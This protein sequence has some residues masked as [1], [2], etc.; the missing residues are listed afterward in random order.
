MRMM[1]RIMA[2]MPG[3][4]SCKELDEK[5]DEY[6]EGELSGWNRFRFAMHFVMCKACAAYAAG[7][8]KT[9]GAV[10]SSFEAE[11]DSSAEDAV[12]EDLV[13]DILKK[14]TNTRP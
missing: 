4:I 10:K 2:K 1:Q 11:D 9:I 8:E 12:P 6:M 7:Y 5:L 3:F 13:Q 14:R